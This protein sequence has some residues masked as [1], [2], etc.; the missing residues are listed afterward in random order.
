MKKLLCLLTIIVILPC[1]CLKTQ[2]VEETCEYISDFEEIVPEGMEDVTDSDALIGRLSVEGIL[3]GIISAIDGE[4]G[5]VS[6]F[7]LTLLGI[8]VFSALGAL[9]PEPLSEV[10][11]SV[12]G[13]VSSAT[14]FKILGDL[15]SEL[16]LSLDKISGFFSLFIPISVGVT[17]LGGGESTAILQGSGMY[18]S[19]SLLSRLSESVFS[20]VI[21]L[22]LAA[23]LISPLGGRILSSLSSG[24]KAIFTRSLGVFTAIITATFSLQ[25]L[26]ASAADNAAMRAARYMASGLIPVVG[27][28]VSGAISTLAS[29]MSYAKSVVGGGAVAVIVALALTPLV[30]ILLYRLCL[31]IAMGISGIACVDSS[32]FSAYRTALDMALSLYALSSLI[33]IFEIIIF[34]KSG[35]TLL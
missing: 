27:S 34:I 16:L 14:I 17:A 33:Y 18:I 30:A 31:S 20:S 19:L 21:S 29:G 26:V 10:V 28:T 22:G 25:T 1:F 4:K 5:R 32:V 15:I 23:A 8:I 24:V 12:I 9:T 3:L 35:V 7:F 11:L 2:A 13:L 6:E